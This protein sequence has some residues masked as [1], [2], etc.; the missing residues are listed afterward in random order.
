[1]TTETTTPEERAEEYGLRRISDGRCPRQ[2]VGKRHL[3][4]KCW[5]ASRLNDHSA[6]YTRHGRRLVAWEPYDGY[7]R[8]LAEVFEAARADGL[9]VVVTGM[10]PWNPGSTFALWFEVAE[11]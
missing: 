3:E 4:D 10:S 5:C 11:S 2:L 7:P 1:M 8:D 6:T 9:S